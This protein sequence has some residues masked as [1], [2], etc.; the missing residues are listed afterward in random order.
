MRHERT[1]L[2]VAT[3]SGLTAYALYLG[4]TELAYLGFGALIGYLGK[5]NGRPPPP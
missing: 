2:T 4:Q 5:V 3:I 1:L